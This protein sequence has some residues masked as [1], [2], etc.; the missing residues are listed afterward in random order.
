VRKLKLTEQNVVQ[1]PLVAYAVAAGW[2][3]LTHD[4]ALAL[5]ANDEGEMFLIPVLR[6]QLKR[7]NPW[8]TEA[9]VD[10]VLSRMRAA[11]RDITGNEELHKWL[12]GD[13]TAFDPGEK[14]ERDVHL[15]DFDDPTSND[16]QVTQEWVQQATDGTRNR[17]DVMFCVNGVPVVLV[18]C[19]SAQRKDGID[20]GLGQ[21]KR[22]HRETPDMVLAA[23]LFEVTHL[24]DFYYGVTWNAAR[25]ALSNWK[26]E[27]PGNFEAKVTK[28]FDPVRLVAAVRDD[29][30][31]LRREEGI[32]KV[33]QRQH[34]TRAI[35][36]AI[37]RAG[38]PR[39]KRGLI[40]HTQGSGKT[41][42]MI[43]VAVRLLTRVPG[44]RPLVLMLIDRN[45]LEGQL[46]ANLKAHGLDTVE[47]AES[48]QHLRKLLRSGY[49]G[50]VVSMLHKF[51][52]I[53]AD[54]D[55]GEDIVVLIDEAHRSTASDLGN[56]LF[57][58]L[59][60][61][62]VIGFTGT[63]IDKTAHGRGTFKTFGVDDDEGYL[64]KYSIGESIEDGTTL[65]LHYALAPN[66]MQVPEQQLEEEFLALADAEGVSDVEELNRVLDRA[67]NL[68]AFLKS[69]DRVDQVAKFVV[70]HFVENVRPLGYKAFLVGV[71]REA[72]VLLKEAL[73]RYFPRERSR[74]V[75]SSAHNDSEELKAHHLDDTQERAIR[76][77]FLEGG[78]ELEILIVTEKLLT[79]FD[80]PMLYCMY[81]DKP[82]RDH[83]LLQAIARV[84]RPYE[85]TD[86]VAKPCGFVIDFVGIFDRLESAL[87]FDSDIVDAVIT[88]LDVLKERFAKAMDEAQPFLALLE[89]TP[90][91][92][93]VEHLL[94][95]FADP[96]ERAAFEEL[97]AELERLYEIISPDAYL[98]PFV[99]RFGA[100]AQL[101]ALLDAAFN[102]KTMIVKE[103]ARKTEELVRSRVG[104]DGLD[105]LL[106]IQKITPEALDHL[107]DDGDDDAATVI[108]LAKSLSASASA[109]GSTQPALI[110]IDARAQDVLAR[111][112]DRQVDT[113]AALEELKE[114][115]EEMLA[116]KQMQERTGLDD[117][118][119]AVHWALLQAG[120]DADALR[121]P[122]STRP[123]TC[124]NT[125]PTRTSV[126]NS[127]CG[128]TA[129]SSMS[130]RRRRL[131]RLSTT[132]WML[133]CDSVG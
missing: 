106:P 109:G 120:L 29:I 101:Q 50:L 12:R 41:L 34:Q 99:D 25:R 1:G 53:E 133:G 23:Q 55:L 36:K 108:N 72:C 112:A 15:V 10:G 96:D 103:L 39:K 69:G 123:L 37:A 48:K 45:E 116:A 113:K 59:P 79:G 125:E 105:L 46:I 95:H 73:D 110:S 68:K 107:K 119:F 33:V 89:G 8:M 129:S 71:D 56:Y 43:A 128:S 61:A 81:L 67:I 126:A 64:D 114:A 19:K 21:V 11:K 30:V 130:W 90:D 9:V 49:R 3:E 85:A 28:F 94:N 127:G 4:E 131:A 82:M 97:F 63:P 7:L 117:R 13:R 70:E 47:I 91:D 124:P 24:V 76:K 58:A 38:D 80:A 60:K 52:G 2:A 35:D 121:R 42:T 104:V 5:R 102:T 66:A 17:A 98:R 83:V 93:L 100:L 51:E 27:E 84:N 111:F 78:S 20:E 118:A 115:M 16:L 122:Y 92:K 74:V 57:G 18:E 22:Y 31:F 62:T 32:T 75:I 40:W 88:N 44:S 87:A 86:G 77:Q 54:V 26:D 14:R 6:G 65:P 132:S